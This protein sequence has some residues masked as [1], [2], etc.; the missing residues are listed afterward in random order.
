VRVADPRVLAAELRALREDL[1]RRARREYHEALAAHRRVGDEEN[2]V[3]LWTAF[4]SYVE[5]VCSSLDALSDGADGS[6]SGNGDGSLAN[7]HLYEMPVCEYDSES[8]VGLA[9]LRTLLSELLVEDDRFSPAQ[10]RR[11]ADAVERAAVEALDL[12]AQPPVVE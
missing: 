9:A 12:A 5:T 3:L 6:D 8:I 2:E 4:R 7:D 10:T 11:A 1:D